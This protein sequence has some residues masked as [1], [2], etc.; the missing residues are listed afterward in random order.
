MEQL[1]E[2]ITIYGEWGIGECGHAYEWKNERIQKCV[3]ECE[4]VFELRRKYRESIK[5]LKKGVM[6]YGVCV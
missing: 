2:A 5:A 3:C 1:E 4:C 6:L